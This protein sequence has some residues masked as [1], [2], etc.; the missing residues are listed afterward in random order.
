MIFISRLRL[1][2]NAFAF[3]FDEQVKQL[4]MLFQLFQALVYICVLTVNKTICYEKRHKIPNSRL[5]KSALMSVNL[6][7]S[8]RNLANTARL[9]YG[10]VCHAMRLCIPTPTPDCPRY[11][12]HLPTEGIGSR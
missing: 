3:A 4:R 6:T 10:L 9:R 2:A 8:V 7:H 5:T 1:N 11:S 12:F